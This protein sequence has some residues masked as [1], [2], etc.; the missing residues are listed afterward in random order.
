MALLLIAGGALHS[1]WATKVTYHIL[2]LPIPDPEVEGNYDFHMQSDLIGKRLEAVK[3]TV[4]N[5]SELEL[6]AHYKSPLATG[7]TYY[8]ATDVIVSG[9]AVQLYAYHTKTKGKYYQVKGIDTA[10]PVPTPVAEHTTLSGS[11]AEYYVIYTAKDT[12]IKLDG[13]VRYNIRTKYKDK[14]VYKD[15]GFFAL[16]R[17]RNNRPAV[18]P[19]GNVDPEMLA[20]EDFMVTPVTGSGVKTYWKD[21]NNKNDEALVGGKFFFMFK[22]EGKDPYNIILR[23][24]YNKDTTYIEPNDDTKEF[25]YKWYKNGAL[26]SVTT[27]NAY[28]ASDDHVKYNIRYNPSLYPTNPTDLRKGDD[29]GYN[30]RP[31]Q[32]HGQTSNAI[33]NSLTL[34]NNT[35]NTGYVFMGT[36]TVD[37]SGVT[38]DAP[39]YLKEKETGNQL[40]FA[41]GD[42]TNNLSV[43]GFYPIKKL[44]FKIATPFY[45]SNPTTDHI[46]SVSDQV[47][48]YTV[49]NDAIVMDYLPQ[50]LKRKYCDF[51][52]KFY[53][54]ALCTEE[55]THFSEADYDNTEGYKV[56]VGYE[57]TSAL[58][59]DTITPVAVY[60]STV[61]NKATWYELTD[62]GSTQEYGRKIKYDTGSSKYKNDG[63]NGEYVKES[64]FA[65]I[66]DPYEL[67]VLYRKGTADA[68]ANRYVTLS[69]YDT[70][71]IPF[72]ETSSSF[73]L[74]KYDD[75]GYW[76]WA[77]G[78][79]SEAVTYG[80]DPTINVG[81]DAQT[82]TF[83]LSG[84]A[85]SK[86]YKITTDGTGVG[87]IVSISPAAGSV[88]GEKATT[89][90]I[91]VK[92]A[93]NTSGAEKQMTI[94]IQEYN[95]DEGA[96][97]SESPANPTV[98]TI[99]QG[100]TSSEFDGNDV[101]YS[102]SSST[103]IK[104]LSLP[105]RA[106]TYNM[107]DL[108]GNIAAKATKVQTIYSP[109]TKDSIPSV[110]FSPLVYGEAFTFFSTYPGGGRGN[111]SSPITELTVGNA[112]SSTDI[113]V[114][115]TTTRLGNMPVSLS[116]NQ[117]FNVKLNNTFVYYNAAKDSIRTN[118]NPTSADLSSPAYL[119]KLRN[120][121]P[122]AMM[123]DN[124]GAREDLG[125]ADQTDNDVKHY[126]T[127][128]DGTY[129]TVSR[130]KGAWIKLAGVLP[131]TDDGT[132]LIFDTDRSHAQRFI[133]KSSTQ[134]G[135]YEVMVATDAVDANT[136]Y[137]NIGC[138]EADTVKVY[139]NLT[140][141]HGHDALKFV[142]NQN[143]NY[144]Y[145]LI[146]KAKHELLTVESKSP[147]LVLPAEFQ[148]P[149]VSRY[150]YYDIDGI[151]KNGTE[152]TV[153]PAAVELS[154]LADLEAT[155][156]T[157]DPQP[158]NATAYGA[159]DAE[160]KHSDAVSTEIIK[161]T[162]KKLTTTGNHYFKIDDNYYVINVTKACYYDIYV[163]Y[164]SNDIV[165][166]NTGSYMLKFL[167][168][169]A[170]GYHLE[171][172]NDNLTTGDKIQAVYPYC[173]GDGNLNIYGN[174]M[175]KEQF[176]GGA[177]TRPRWIW[178]FDSEN[179]DP[180][181]VRVRSR[182]TISYNSVSHS[183][184]LT[185]YAVHFNQDD[186][187]D[188][189]HIVTGGT[190]PGVASVTPMEYMVLGIQGSYQLLTTDSIDDG[191]TKERR[192]VTSFEQYWKTYNMLKLHVLGI[193]KSTNA[194]SDD[195]RT[196]VVP[197][198]QRTPLNT[199][200]EALGVGS[201]NW[202]SYDAY[203]NATRWN[204]Y[205]DK[206]NGEEKKVVEKIEHW[207]QTFD[208]GNGTFDIESADVPPVLVLLDLHGWEIMR[209]PLPTT[210]YPNGEELDA[211]RVYDSPLVDK[212][213]FY[214]NATKATG[215]HRYSLR[216][217]NGAERDQIKVNGERYSSESLGKLPPRNA[218]GVVS[219]GVIQDQYVIY[220]VKEEYANNYSYT[221]NGHPADS[222][223]T[224]TEISQPYLVLQNGRFYKI[225]NNND[226]LSYFTKPIHEHTNPEGGNVYDLIVSPK[227][228]GGNHNIIDNKGNFL[229]NNFWF[230]KPN[231]NIDEEMGI[232][233][234][235]VTGVTDI[236][237]AK[238]VVKK[239]YW[240][241]N[242]S[243]FDPYN[244]QL[245]LKNKTDGK[246][247]GRYITSHMDTAYLANG[248]ME[249][250]YDGGGTTNM[251]LEA[252]GSVTVDCE[253]YDHTTVQITNQT[254]MAVSDANRNMQLM[255]RFD[256]T[257]RV[258]VA[259]ANPWITT[260][261][262]PADHAK[263]SADNNG[264]MGPQTTFFKCPQRFHYHIIDNNGREALGYKRGADFY[265]DI[266]EH[267]KSPLA[268]DFT[269]YTGLAEVNGDSTTCTPGEWA[270]ATGVYKR[271]L[272]KD[273]LY[274]DAVKLLPDSGM[275]YFRIGTRGNFKWRKVLISKGLSQKL[276]TGSFAEAG[277]D[278]VDCPVY[279]R[280]DYDL[281]ADLEADRILQGQ[282]YT[283]Q[284][285]GKDLKASGTVSILEG[286]SQGTGVKLYQ[287][288]DKPVTIDGDDKKW[289]WKFFVAPAD[290]ASDYYVKPDPYA[291]HLFNRYSNY[292]TN[293]SLEPSPMSIGIK[294]PDDN[295][296]FDRFA[297]LSHTNGGY[298][299]VVAKEY[300]KNDHY[301]FLNGA[302]MTTSVSADTATEADFNY[303]Y[304]I[305]SEHAQVVLNHDVKHNY[306]YYII[307]N[308]SVLALTAT[309][310]ADEAETHGFNPYV[311]E[312][313][314]TP[315]LNME[316]YKYYGFRKPVSKYEVIEQT[317]L[318]SLCG[319]YDDSVY[320][321]YN[322]YDIDK[323]SFK[324]PNKRNET[325]E[326]EV[327]RDE[328]SVDVSMNINGELPYNIIWKDDNIMQSTNN[329]TISDGG[330]HALSGNENY[331]WYF[332]GNDPYSLRIKHK[333]GK[334]ID[335]TATL[336]DSADATP[337]MLLRKSGY[338]YGVLAQTGRQT[339]M[340]SFGGHDANPHTMSLAESDP[341][342]FI[343]F[344]L[345]IHD[346]IY[347]LI[348]ANT[349]DTVNIPY[350]EGDETTYPA[351]YVWTGDEV[352]PIQGTTQRDLL[353]PED[354]GKLP[355]SKYQLGD[356]AAWGNPAVYHTYCYDAGSVS[357]GDELVLPNA[358]ARPNCTFDFYI[359]GVY[360]YSD[361]PES[362]GT[363]YTEMN[364]KYKGLKLNKL[365]SDEHLIDQ[366]VVVN[367]VY[368]FDTTLAT[369]TGL[370]FV[371][372]TDQN[373]W[374]T[375]ETQQGA[376]PY[377]AHYTNAW[378]LQS[379]AGAETRY[380]ND[381]LWTPLGDVYGFKMYN[382]YMLKNSGGV[383]NVMTMK[384]PLS[385]SDTL[386][387]AV[388][389]TGGYTKGNEI[390]E[391][392]KGDVDGYFRVHPVVN[393]GAM[394]YYVRRDPTDNYTK[395]STTPCD[396][397][398]GLDMTLLE[399]YYERA[400]YVGGLTDKGKE[401]YEAAV[402]TGKIIDIQAIVYADSNIVAYKPGY[403]R[404]HNQPGV[405]GISPVRYASGYL[406]DIEKTAVSGG[407]PMHFYSEEG[408][409][410]IF[411]GNEDDL[412]TGFTITHATRGDI[413]IAPTEYDPSTIFYIQGGINPED[414]MDT[415]NPRVVMQT[416][417]LYVK[418]NAEDENHGDAVMTAT[419]GEATTFSVMDIGGAVLL[420]HDGDI[421]ASR[422]Y[423]HY[424]Q[425]YEVNSVNMIYDLKYFHNSP[426]DDAK[427]CMQP[428]QKTAAVGHGE[429]P[430]KIYT[431]NGGDGYYYATFY[432][433]FDVL[434]PN[435][436]GDKT[437]NA[438]VCS[439][440][441]DNGVHP[442]AV[443]AHDTI[444]E[445][446]FVPAGT[447]VIIRVK[448]E[449]GSLTLTLPTPSPSSP[450]SCIFT[451]S[452]LEKKLDPADPVR[453]VYTL[454]LPM[455]SVVSKDEDD[456]G[457]TG[458]INAPVPEFATS[459]VGFYINATLDKE[460][461]PK[462]S[463]WQRNNLYVQHNKIYYRAPAEPSLT[464]KHNSGV[465]FVPVI[466]EGNEQ[467]PEGKNP[468]IASDGVYDILGR[469]VASDA[470]AKDGSWQH[471]LAPGIYIVNG[472][473]IYIH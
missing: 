253:G 143:I 241:N 462:E 342:K 278:S 92:L 190:L 363:P 472:Q 93:A 346:L 24:A 344:G 358:F 97:P 385:E 251:T 417:G 225:E 172:G 36:R 226:N 18:L 138:G 200:L 112:V 429:M 134:Q 239:E 301:Q 357:I 215:C 76:S 265:P 68:N 294:V 96:T 234:T 48:Q 410:M 120:R 98:I 261:E 79:A 450:V 4:D 459:G 401:R 393:Q 383:Q 433:P 404:L 302:N 391:L 355:G 173:N 271:T 384:S 188:T 341:N 179:S 99:N 464:P 156:E 249:G 201:G 102:T 126:N 453:D 306:T 439:K 165:Q 461:D 32:L 282:W 367:I 470:E 468:I 195:A 7:F 328:H 170:E 360:R 29:Q 163:T 334:Y 5:Q 37:G 61:W 244:L 122:Y 16:N 291:I 377:L 412:G 17:G 255:P 441:D 151:T 184:Y 229:G 95:D 10:D 442:T 276:I 141:A 100:T 94:T 223:Y 89:E 232:P 457:S 57:L 372:S 81:K 394:R 119:W 84:L 362:N 465:E 262:E 125:V 90:S 30:D 447:S 136:T 9:S 399:P 364:N 135:I 224:E 104:V 101:S 327:E 319:L 434:L 473:K 325:G 351:D 335:G 72:D 67:K 263:A 41:T 452:Y 3:V 366:T 159:A 402:D 466:F 418:G 186:D 323:T 331:V 273:T 209:R 158:S 144:T 436:V 281:D 245:Q 52:G 369:N 297:L 216:M 256:H 22:F 146:D 107:V 192:K 35:D 51:T 361:N 117:E 113:Y 211:L 426:T 228:H 471:R 187:P 83:N 63:A 375:F 428:V 435:D 289:Q 176:N 432:A 449:S 266:T 105:A 152:Y 70:W 280:Y 145:R 231:Q 149:L 283:V 293:P 217:Q 13:S 160:H 2:T 161:E 300:D 354:E 290:S 111:L 431:N 227:N 270:T 121:D 258:N 382:R 400:G 437:Y 133:A 454:G 54:D 140:Y 448:D 444:A 309:Q 438:Y 106:Y 77:A 193:D 320:V 277:Y 312:S 56:Y 381:Y 91:T 34:L 236:N 247:D 142:L 169:F 299:L 467:Q 390:F 250:G 424:S 295:N 407:I 28:I 268:K 204:G 413:P 82:I 180:Y 154:V 446:K 389:G 220:T 46:I 73:L 303:K 356:S 451:G 371:T 42:A 415:H 238:Y 178:Y 343:I 14:N 86:Y 20:S 318:K 458:D 116:E 308:D 218:T 340:L 353:T 1:V 64:E 440:W 287:G 185:T 15:R 463:L 359:E 378:G 272:T 279:V 388:P 267:F 33:W 298:A 322:A 25:V 199:R 127:A 21:N 365:M 392:I 38:P 74:R 411:D 27:S 292:T 183:T 45:K 274:R 242:K 330:A 58:P 427:W 456:Y 246:T 430:L 373:L 379:M 166:F 157:E 314:Q 345:S 8:N 315:L 397:R 181:H 49:D 198:S 130:Q 108:A 168:P 212:Y 333:G 11:S 387:L 443:P 66:G 455:T 69:T 40:Y 222:T 414:P 257:K 182:S 129:T 422:K 403:Y 288:T 203:A 349:G 191:A 62:E 60:D 131:T 230:I 153:K 321:R 197:E 110:I 207:Y 421:P 219:G 55:I 339:Y 425:S 78:H 118:A 174:E 285:D 240:D 374:Y 469:K 248:I 252:S 254:F 155:T 419:A 264:S 311:P 213:Y 189:K 420:I 164:E 19:T 396:W 175:Q 235:K 259:S 348:I 307:T 85:G 210:T 47:S 317:I 123:V 233:W 194:Y 260:L 147:D 206:T 305:I 423:L 380:T 87:Q 376:K 80:D 243:G 132:H 88:H 53:K 338:D 65:F 313:A 386:L 202:H 39:Y 148:S 329:S 350:R 139:N 332:T 316:D 304:G 416:Q 109:L 150:H 269:Y 445:G 237:K 59:F 221:F 368:A 286:A 460:S 408:L 115:Y 310:T 395:L 114:A 208:M 196:W 296:G 44:T 347:R 43:E 75:T 6:P 324:I 137:Y 284:L 409:S 124:L 398:F 275:Y 352:K 162:A 12:I 177:S 50:S 26:F 71:D 205:N 23:T 406:H 171:D 214:S 128:G 103:R 167:D 336:R 326:G 31:G 370:G 405:S 337:F